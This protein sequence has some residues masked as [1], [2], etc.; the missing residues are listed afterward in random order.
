MFSVFILCNPHC[1]RHRGNVVSKSFHSSMHKL[2]L[3]YYLHEK[4]FDVFFIKNISFISIYIEERHILQ[5]KMVIFVF[6]LVTVFTL[7]V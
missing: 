4:A 6:S 3:K 2:M 5:S 1:E 7:S